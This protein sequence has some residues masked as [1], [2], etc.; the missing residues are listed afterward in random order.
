VTASA[1]ISIATVSTELSSVVFE[2]SL[3]VRILTFGVLGK[4]NATFGLSNLSAFCASLQQL[5]WAATERTVGAALRGRPSVEL[6]AGAATEGR[7]YSAF[8]GALY[9]W[10]FCW[11]GKGVTVVMVH[12]RLSP[13]NFALA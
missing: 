10:R 9:S 4:D 6:R 1:A 11:G 13:A 8:C 5:E 7:P 3:T 12:L 2:W